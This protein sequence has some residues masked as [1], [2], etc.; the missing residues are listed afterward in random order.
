MDAA[1]VSDADSTNSLFARFHYL[2]VMKAE[3]DHHDPLIEGIG[4]LN[5][6]NRLDHRSSFAASAFQQLN[7]NGEIPNKVARRRAHRG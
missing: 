1:D 3:T 4:P 5:R 2:V 6:D 7:A